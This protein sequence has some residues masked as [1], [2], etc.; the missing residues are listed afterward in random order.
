MYTGNVQPYTIFND[1]FSNTIMTPN[2]QNTLNTQAVNAAFSAS[3]KL[4]SNIYDVRMRQILAQKLYQISSRTPTPLKVLTQTPSDKFIIGNDILSNTQN[5]LSNI[6]GFD[7][8]SVLATIL[9]YANAAMRGRYIVHPTSTWIEH[10][11]LY[12]ML[13]AESGTRKSKLHE[14]LSAPF[15]QMQAQ[16]LDEYADTAKRIKLAT[17]LTNKVKSAKRTSF[18]RAIC[19]LLFD[20][21][22]GINNPRIKYAYL[23]YINMSRG[24]E[25]F[26]D[27]LYDSYSSIMIDI[28][29]DIN[30]IKKMQKNCGGIAIFSAEGDKFLRRY[31]NRVNDNAIPN[32]AY[33]AEYIAY[34]SKRNQVEIP[35]PFLTIMLLAQTRLAYNFFK[36]STISESGLGAR[37][38]SIIPERIHNGSIDFGSYDFTDYNNL[39]YTILTEC[40]Q[41]CKEGKVV[42][43]YLSDSAKDVFMNFCHEME[44]IE[45]PGKVDILKYSLG[46]LAGT[47]LRLAATIHVLIHWYNRTNLI[48]KETMMLAVNVA[49]YLHNCK[50]YLC[51]DDGYAAIINAKKILHWAQEHNHP[52]FT[53]RNI[54][55]QTEVRN[56]SDIFIALNLLE[57]HGY[58]A[59]VLSPN[60]PRLIGINPCIQTLKIC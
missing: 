46:K 4:T 55:Q 13:I 11:N 25:T 36:A 29:T 39:I 2:V 7:L 51:A 5:A 17:E 35:S 41:M 9:G 59:Q 30:L 23:R 15:V 26:S 19:R 50:T 20:K 57:V 42:D 27:G 32:K 38:C 40:M 28:S 22:G 16:V 21:Y 37:F 34:G 24:I 45:Y 54:A 44:Y 31:I 52:I 58:I 33:D 53:S 12:T 18:S 48:T 8:A 47:T 3:E 43:L 49:K 14:V 1:A 10:T 60:H 6:T 56:N